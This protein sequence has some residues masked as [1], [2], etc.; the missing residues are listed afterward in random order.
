M[1]NDIRAFLNHVRVEKGLAE[2]TVA[3]YRRDL[4]KLAVFA[5]AHSLDTRKFR[6]D[7]VVEFLGSLYKQR[8]DSRSVARHLVTLRN[9]FRFALSERWIKVDPTL[10]LESPK[11]WKSLP[12][13]LTIG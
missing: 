3:A 9:F 11:I 7:D 1:E 12:G 8:L 5:T 4:G 13:C 6:R 2:N 10:N